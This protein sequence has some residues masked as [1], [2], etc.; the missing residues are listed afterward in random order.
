MK[1]KTILGSL[2]AAMAVGSAALLA[3]SAMQ[4][5]SWKK[6]TKKKAKGALK[7]MEGMLDDMQDLLK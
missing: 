6:M 2:G 7:A 5:P 4:T 1:T 3:R